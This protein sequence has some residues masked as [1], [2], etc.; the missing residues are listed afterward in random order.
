MRLTVTR[1]FIFMH[2]LA[3]PLI[4]F[5][6]LQLIYKKETT[7]HGKWKKNWP[8]VLLLAIYINLILLCGMFYLT[9]YPTG[10]ILS[11]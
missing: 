7:A 4:S 1:Y 10:L 2:L 5:G 3:L 9:Y 8:I 6:Y 11:N